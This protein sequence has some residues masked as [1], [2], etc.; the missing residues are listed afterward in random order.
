MLL[1]VSTAT[2]TVM[3]GCVP[4]TTPTPTQ[5]PQNQQPIEIMSVVGPLQPFIPAGPEVEITL[6]NVSE[7]PV[8]ALKAT[9]ELGKSFEFNFV[10]VTPSSPLLPGESSSVKRVLIE[11]GFGSGIPYPLM[12]NVTLQNGVTLVYTKQVQIAEPTPD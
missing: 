3:V 2:L 9:L 1:I 11:G 12:I 4:P 8:I 6:K 7:V 10:S 5:S